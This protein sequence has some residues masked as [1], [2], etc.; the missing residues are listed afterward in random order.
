MDRCI[1]A[2]PRASSASQAVTLCRTTERCA[3]RT[4]LILK[5]SC[6]AGRAPC[7]GGGCS[8]PF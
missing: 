6:P 7:A 4:C 1:D 3:L 5:R 8:A 2:R